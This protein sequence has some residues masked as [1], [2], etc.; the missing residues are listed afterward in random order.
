MWETSETEPA[1]SLSQMKTPDD[2]D[3]DVLQ[4]RIGTDE[5][6]APTTVLLA[7]S[8]LIPNVE[9]IRASLTNA[10]L[11][12][13]TV[14]TS[15]LVTDNSLV[16]VSMSFE[17]DFFD[18]N[19]EKAHGSN[20]PRGEVLEAWVRP[21]ATATCLSVDSVGRRQGHKRSWFPLGV[22]NVRFTDGVEVPLPSQS[23]LREGNDRDES[24]EF[25][26]A[27]RVASGF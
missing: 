22:V 19:A 17:P 14:W 21:L 13:P 15:F 23:R 16:K 2:A 7:V 12:G 1:N 9:D 3:W 20:P 8:A 24:D 6:Y 18:Q 10:D 4:R 5:L 11:S 26:H 27:L 25:L